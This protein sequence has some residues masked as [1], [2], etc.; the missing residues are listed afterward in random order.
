M[1]SGEFCWSG[2]IRC[3]PLRKTYLPTSMANVGMAGFSY[4]SGKVVFVVQ[5]VQYFGVAVGIRDRDAVFDDLVWVWKN[6][7]DFVS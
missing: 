6:V 4:V 2:A 7:I 3:H 5:G 1:C